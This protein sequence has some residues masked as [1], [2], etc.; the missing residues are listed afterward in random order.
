MGDLKTILK[1]EKIRGLPFYPLLCLPQKTP[2][3]QVLNA[4]REKRNGCVIAMD[5]KKVTGILTERDVLTRVVEQKLDPETPM[6]KVMTP[7]PKVLKMEDSVADA[8]RLMNQGS[9]RHLPILD[10]SGEVQ[11]LVSVRQIIRYLAEHFPYEVY[12]L[13]PN[14]QIIRAPEGA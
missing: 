2:L 7:N 4:M 3:R 12:N 5:G 9:Y 13:P 11:G 14:P 10:A 1:E 8:I 6:E